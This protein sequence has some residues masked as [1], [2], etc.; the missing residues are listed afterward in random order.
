MPRRIEVPPR[1]TQAPVRVPTRRSAGQNP[2]SR[3]K[4]SGVFNERHTS[5]QD[6]LYRDWIDM[7]T[8]LTFTFDDGDEMVGILRAYDTYALTVEDGGGAAVLIFKQSLRL[9]KPQ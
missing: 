9:I 7:E 5:A 8:P 3:K 4:P 1:D 6:G 2:R